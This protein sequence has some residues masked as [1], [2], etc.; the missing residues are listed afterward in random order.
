MIQFRG[1]RGLRV[2]VRD[3][4]QNPRKLRFITVPAG[5]LAGRLGD[6]SVAAINYPEAT[7]AGLYP[8]R[9]AIGMEDGRSPYAGVLTIRSADKR[10]PWVGQLISAYRSDGIKRYILEHYHDSVRRPW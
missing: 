1:D 8:A 3:I 6:V 7:K 9:D 4:A 10:Q 5:Q 2:T